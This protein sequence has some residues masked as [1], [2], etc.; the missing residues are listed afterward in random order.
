MV[1]KREKKL[2]VASRAHNMILR[3]ALMREN[4]Y[5][6]EYMNTAQNTKHNNIDIGIALELGIAFL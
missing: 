6:P 2:C 3:V 5:S 1:E 4:R